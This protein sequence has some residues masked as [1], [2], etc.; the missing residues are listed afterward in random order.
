MAQKYQVTE[1]KNIIYNFFTEPK[2]TTLSIT[3]QA[4]IKL[5]CYI[6]LIGNYEITGFGRIQ[7][8]TITDFRIIQQEVR[9]AYVE[10]DDDSVLEFIRSIPKEQLSEWELD[11]HSHVEMGTFASGTDMNN[12]KSMSDLRG[13]KQFPVMIVNKQQEFTV[14]N[15]ISPVNTPEISLNVLDDEISKEEIDAIY[16]EVKLDI[17]EKCT[18]YITPV[19]TY[20]KY[21][22]KN[23]YKTN[24]K[25]YFEVCASCGVKLITNH[26][27]DIGLCEDC[28]YEMS[29][30]LEGEK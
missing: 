26:E 27:L 25:S 16:N 22:A 12:Y 23:T 28:E 9:A 21:N 14:M 30:D 7:N 15:Y 11:W 29:K 8:G 13:N 19:T 24:T 18:K 17:E 20:N 1:C 2:Y 6:N 10:C 4:Y 3:K 5:M